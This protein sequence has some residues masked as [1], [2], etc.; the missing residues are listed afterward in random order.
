MLIFLILQR[1]ELKHHLPGLAGVTWL[2]MAW[3][4]LQ[5]AVWL[6]RSCPSAS[7]SLLST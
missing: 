4:G 6:H 5:Q 2:T 1:V 7:S 3:L